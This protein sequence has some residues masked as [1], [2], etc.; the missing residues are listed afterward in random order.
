MAK[1]I[2]KYNNGSIFIKKK[3]GLYKKYGLKINLMIMNASNILK[4]ATSKFTCLHVHILRME[5]PLS[6][7]SY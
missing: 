2:N 6:E 7:N 5:Y 4:L 3:F 1:F